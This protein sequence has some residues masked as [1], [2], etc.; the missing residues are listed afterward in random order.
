MR[1]TKFVQTPCAIFQA[2][3]TKI[4][5]LPAPSV[6][7]GGLTPL[8]RLTSFA[9][10]NFQFESRLCLW[11]N[12]RG[13]FAA[14]LTKNTLSSKQ[15]SKFGNGNKQHFYSLNSTGYSSHPTFPTSSQTGIN[16]TATCSTGKWRP[17]RSCIE[18]T[19]ASGDR[20]TRTSVRGLTVFSGAVCRYPKSCRG[21]DFP[22]LYLALNGLPANK[23]WFKITCFEYCVCTCNK[24][25]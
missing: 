14:Q 18:H 24:K 23:N 19:G 25:I 16:C 11:N 22:P 6:D 13:Y 3:S 4:H 2:T 12:V 5:I 10:A 20:W 7:F 1:F 21:L 9:R 15:F 8:W 17:A